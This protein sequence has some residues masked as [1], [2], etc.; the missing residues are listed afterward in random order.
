MAEEIPKYLELSLSL[1]AAQRKNGFSFFFDCFCGKKKAKILFLL[2]DSSFLFLLS[3]PF[4]SSPFSTTTAEE[5][6]LQF[7][8]QPG[9]LDFLRKIFLDGNV[10]M[11]VR[12][13]A[14]I[15]FKNTIKHIWV[16]SDETQRDPLSPEEREQIKVFKYFLFSSLFFSFLFLFS[17]LCSFFF[18]FFF[19]NLSFFDFVVFDLGVGSLYSPPNSK[20]LS[21]ILLLRL[22]FV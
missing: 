16:H 18:E 11:V 1:D 2:I 5:Q 19:F 9:Y 17:F 8:N 15:Q 3:P 22:V 6:L 20:A 14:A 4:L 12:Q 13:S 10:S 7:R 21:R